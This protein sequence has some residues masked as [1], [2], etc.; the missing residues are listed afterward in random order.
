MRSHMYDSVLEIKYLVQVAA[1][2]DALA[3]PRQLRLELPFA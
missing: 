1:N 2:F 3:N